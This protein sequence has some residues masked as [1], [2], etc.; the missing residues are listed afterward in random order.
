MMMLQM[1]NADQVYTHRNTGAPQSSEVPFLSALNDSPALLLETGLT[2]STRS[3]G[4]NNRFVA[5]SNACWLSICSSPA[6]D[7]AA[8]HVPL[9]DKLKR[10]DAQVASQDQ[11]PGCIGCG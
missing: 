5:L 1:N 8:F 7:H 2:T 11:L 4:K 6:I 10:G 9:P 3:I